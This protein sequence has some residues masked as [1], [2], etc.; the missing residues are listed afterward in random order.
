MYLCKF[1]ID[2]FKL[3]FLTVFTVSI[4]YRCLSAIKDER[5][6]ASKVLTGPPESCYAGDKK[7]FINA[8]K[9]A[10]YASKI[11]SYAQVSE[12]YSINGLTY[13]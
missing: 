9:D 10:I 11:I 7:E 4:H 13:V 5:V 3:L 2:Y 6:K 12:F 8:I 1:N